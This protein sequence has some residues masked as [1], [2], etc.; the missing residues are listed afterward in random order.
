M[1]RHRKHISPCRWWRGRRRLLIWT[2]TVKFA[3]ESKK[4]R[5]SQEQASENAR[6]PP[7]I[8]RGS[9]TQSL[10]TVNRRPEAGGRPAVC[11]S[12]VVAMKA[13]G[14]PPLRIV[15]LAP[16]ATSI[17]CAIDAKRSLVGVT[18]WCA[19]VAPVGK[20]PKLGD[21]WHMKSSEEILQL[22]PILVIGSVLYK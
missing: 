11:Y 13:N 18:K 1:E 22:K 8:E 6:W 4:A 5:L 19:D 2:A 14:R 12:V 21:C 16:S 17:L 3:P 20:L 7:K 15:S 9:A 10:R